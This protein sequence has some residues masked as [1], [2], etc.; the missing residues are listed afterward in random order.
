MPRREIPRYLIV[1]TPLVLAKLGT[2]RPIFYSFRRPLVYRRQFVRIAARLAA[3][4][5]F[6]GETDDRSKDRI[7]AG[8]G[9]ARDAD[10]CGPRAGLSLAAGQDHRS[11]RRR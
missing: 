5:T 1:H 6:Q 4:K 11:L 9:F 2:P 7:G 10:P 3:Q 8:R